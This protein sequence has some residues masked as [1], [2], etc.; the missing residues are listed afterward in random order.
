MPTLRIILWCNSEGDGKLLLFG[1]N[2]SVYNIA[3]QVKNNRH[4]H[5][6]FTCIAYKMKVDLLYFK[7]KYYRYTEF[8]VYK[9]L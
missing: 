4:H 1:G 6:I 3:K 5:T 2:L 7:Y 8:M 9:P